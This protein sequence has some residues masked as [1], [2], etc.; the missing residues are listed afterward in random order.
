[1]PYRL[2]DDLSDDSSGSDEWALY[3]LFTRAI[4]DT[5]VKVI[6]RGEYQFYS[7]THVT[8]QVEDGEA[9]LFVWEDGRS[10]IYQDEVLFDWAREVI[11]GDI[12]SI[13]PDDIDTIYL[14]GSV[15]LNDPYLYIA[16]G[17]VV[18]STGDPTRKGKY[19]Q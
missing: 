12:L 5:F 18:I 9:T 8:L 19:L 16:G 15:G 13:H 6:V 17:E 3:E 1:M 11:G 2:L 4:F 10:F 7:A 14:D